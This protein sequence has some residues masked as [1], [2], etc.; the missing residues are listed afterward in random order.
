MKKKAGIILISTVIIAVCLLTLFGCNEKEVISAYDIAVNNGFEGTEQEWL[1][2]L[3]GTDGTNGLNGSDGENGAAYFSIDDVYEA[4]VKRGYTGDFM[5]F[6][7]EYV[8]VSVNEDNTYSVSNSILSA[9]IV[10]SSF[11]EKKI[12]YESFFG[13]GKEVLDEVSYG[14]AGVI[15]KMDKEQGSAYIITNFH[16]VY[17][18]NST[19]ANHVSEDIKVYLYGSVYAE[20][21]INATFV[22]GSAYYDIAVLRVSDSDVLKN[23]DAKAVTVAENEVAV[24]QTAIAIG[25]PASMGMSVTSGIVSVDSE[26]IDVKVDDV[27]SYQLRVMRVDTAINSGNSGGGLFDSDGKLIGIVN[28][29]Y[30][31]TSIENIGYAIPATL[32]T[33]VADN[34]IAN[35]TDASKIAVKRCLIGV[36]TT[37]A[38]SH[39]EYD[40]ATGKTVIIETIKV[41]SV[42]AGGASDGKLEMDDIL[43]GVKINGK[44]YTVTR[45]YHLSEK[46]ISAR[47]GDTVTIYYE[48]NGVKG[49]VEYTFGEEDAVEYF[50]MG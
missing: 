43:T 36:T 16:V 35:C 8:K 2:S 11:T 21:A 38:T 40:A 19:Q 3:K 37:I 5:T 6:I 49:E 22:G 17:D 50:V 45:S 25:F 27:N 48:R 28:A 33:T 30:S 31:N 26:N 42:N 15:Y 1:D 4:A 34:I 13:P 7:S 14:G 41:Y 24:G 39:A 20:T 12:V 32:A 18:A 47:V 10:S 23:S 29:K 44:T 9:V 46:L